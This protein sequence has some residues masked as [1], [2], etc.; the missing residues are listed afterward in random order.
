MKSE[1]G[2]TLIMVLVAIA[3]LGLIAVIFAGGIST[4]AKSVF[5]SDERVTAE[6]LARSQLE[7]IKN[8]TYIYYSDDPHDTYDIISTPEGYIINL[9]VA[10]FDPDTST[11]YSESDGVFDGDDGIQKITVTVDHHD[12]EAV[13]TLEDYKVDR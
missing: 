3:I 13:F 12:K 2:F 8:Q 6:S 1:K 9:D 7:S 10:P 5:V 4:G 11:P